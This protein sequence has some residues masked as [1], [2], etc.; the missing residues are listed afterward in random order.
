MTLGLELRA[1][2]LGGRLRSFW[3]AVSKTVIGDVIATAIAIVGMSVLF[4][5]C[6]TGVIW[7]MRGAEVVLRLLGAG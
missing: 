2:S 5:A 7:L 4:L 1:H 6:A 3:V